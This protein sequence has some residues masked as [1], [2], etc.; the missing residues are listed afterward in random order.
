MNPEERQIHR[1]LTVKSL[2][3]VYF[4]WVRQNVNK[5]TAKSKTHNGFMYSLNQEKYLRTFLSDGEVPMDNNGLSTLFRTYFIRSIQVDT[6]LVFYNLASH[7][8]YGCYTNSHNQTIPF[9]ILQD[10]QIP[11]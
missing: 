3:D 10:F 2:V 7:V 11:Y 5:V 8:F 4:S 6:P 9:V 1:Q